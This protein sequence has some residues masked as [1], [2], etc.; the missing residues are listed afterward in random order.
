MKGQKLKLHSLKIVLQIFNVNIESDKIVRVMSQK[1]M[2]H[3]KIKF[4]NKAIK[5]KEIFI[6]STV[7]EVKNVEKYYGNKSNLNESTK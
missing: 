3:K 6:M 5:R 2:A 7:L 4:Y 1:S